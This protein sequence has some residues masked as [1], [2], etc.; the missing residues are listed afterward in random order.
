MSSLLF[1][2][3][4]FVAGAVLAWFAGRA[5]STRLAVQAESLRSEAGALRLS[6]ARLTAEL[7]SAQE[8]LREVKA[9]AAAGEERRESLL[10]DLSAVSSQLAKAQ[11]E[12]DAERAAG[13]ER[14]ALVLG[15]KEELTN[16]FKTLA[17]EILEEKSKRFTDHN[18]ENMDRLLGPL[19]EKLGEF[20]LKVEGLQNDGVV[21]RTE[22]R[23]HI[24]TLAKL[25][26]R[27][28]AEASSLAAALKG[29]SKKQ[30]DW[31]EVLLERMLEDAGLEPGREYRVQESF[32]R[33]DGTRARPRSSTTPPTASAT[34]RLRARLRWLATSGPSANT[35]A[36]W[37]SVSIRRSTSCSRSTLW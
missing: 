3:L 9:A 10:R 5:S 25:N 24:E 31:G 15:A 19:R 37:P 22:L 4:G 35:C 12:L 6:E 32:S 30:G 16:Q 7:A 26:D 23:T 21:G 11:A 28:S 17:G 14:L 34:T 27:L 2:L 1:L 13:P 20:Q 36:A 18:R 33:E 29:S 8:R